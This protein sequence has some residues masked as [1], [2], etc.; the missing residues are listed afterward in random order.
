MSVHWN[1][2]KAAEVKEVIH[3]FEQLTDV[4]GDGGTVRG[5]LPQVLLVNLTDSWRRVPTHDC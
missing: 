4:V 2:H 1:L 5:Q 3:K